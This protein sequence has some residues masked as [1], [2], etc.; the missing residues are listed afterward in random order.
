MALVDC[1]Y[2]ATASPLALRESLSAVGRGTRSYNF[3]P[4]SEPEV[5]RMLVA[6]GVSS[7]A[8]AQ[9]VI[10][11]A[12]RPPP[13]VQAFGLV[14]DSFAVAAGRP[15]VF[16]A[17]RATNQAQNTGSVDWRHDVVALVLREDHAHL[18]WARVIAALDFPECSFSSSSSFQFV[19]NVTLNCTSPFPTF[20][21]LRRPWANAR[22]HIDALRH[23]ISAPIDAISF[24]P[25]DSSKFI[26]A[27]GSPPGTIV[28]P[29]NQCFMNQDLYS[30]VLRLSQTGGPD[31]ALTA[32]A[33]LDAAQQQVPEI[34]L[35]A[36]ARSKVLE[37]CDSDPSMLDPV[38]L[39]SKV[40]GT[41]LGGVLGNLIVMPGTASV[42][43]LQRSVLSRLWE[44]SRPLTTTALFNLARALANR[45][46]GEH[47]Q[48]CENFINIGRIIDRCSILSNFPY[49]A[50]TA[51]APQLSMEVAV[52]FA[53]A[54]PEVEARIASELGTMFVAEVTNASGVTQKSFRLDAWLQWCLAEDSAGRILDRSERFVVACIGFIKRVI[55]SQSNVLLACRTR[56]GAPV[57]GSAAESNQNSQNPISQILIAA[58]ASAQDAAA[59]ESV[60]RSDV[61]VTVL[62]R[63]RSYHASNTTATIN[64]KAEFQKVYQSACRVFPLLNAL[65]DQDIEEHANMLFKKIYSS[66][67]NVVDFVELMRGFKSSSDSRE[68]DVFACMVQS[69]FKEFQYFHKYPDKELQI[70]GKLFGMLIQNNLIST[71]QALKQA[72]Q[73]VLEAI[74]KPPPPVGSKANGNLYRFGVY[75]LEQ[76]KSRLPG[77]PIFCSQISRI[78]HL[79]QQYPQFV[80]EIDALQI[81]QA[82]QLEL[83]GGSVGDLVD[84]EPL[85]EGSSANN[86]G[87]IVSSVDGLHHPHHGVGNRSGLENTG[88]HSHQ[89][90]SHESSSI[91][92]GRASSNE[93]STSSTLT[94]RINSLGADLTEA[95]AALAAGQP[96]PAILP[97]AAAAAAAAKEAE[98]RA[99]AAA[100]SGGGHGQGAEGSS[101]IAAGAESNAPPL[102]VADRV[103]FLV[104]NMTESN[105]DA[106]A[107]EAV[108]IL[109]PHHRTWLASYLV[110]KRV[111][112]QPNFQPLYKAFVERFASREVERF[113]DSELEKAILATTLEC[114]KR[115]LSNEKIKTSTTER[116]TLKNI[117]AW[118][119]LITL[120]RSK[121]LL[122][123]DLNM[124]EL[125]WEAY[126]TGKLFPVVGF[127]V[128]VLKCT[129]VSSVFRPPNPWTVAVLSA[130]RELYD[131]EDIKLNL[132]FEVEV[133]CEHLRLSF[134]MFLLLA[135]FIFVS[136][137]I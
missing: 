31:V 16:A 5:A 136:A 84:P 36:M 91:V 67:M 51:P 100:S 94:S 92:T 111:A 22:A 29:L 99:S 66:Q 21:L 114:A 7:A 133:L 134:K 12:P 103:T 74:K 83:K 75:A 15:V 125:L 101:G 96:I 123:K 78:P 135:I 19:V 97:S 85:L 127:I 119:G 130:L 106:E 53:M 72:L 63:L 42:Y 120:S 9:L 69:L 17:G 18:D 28:G 3:V 43:Q 118:L 55:A 64:T 104:N 71:P 4:L 93:T 122:Y 126:E 34:L 131:V 24:V 113:G 56:S 108:S 88:D 41:Q 46:V 59:R 107:A 112:N 52:Y 45:A 61:L 13:P 60:V 10:A 20:E 102:A 6:M 115:Y 121:P 62:K 25:Q 68:R 27:V 32:A 35:L 50:L 1:G 117:G 87:G 65:V 132:K 90:H 48:L 129:A 80:A 49:F 37:A 58:E 110:T 89:L 39:R 124:K 81:A 79:R 33:I 137:Q 105:V 47:E 116:S 2:S 76:F 40:F 95:L 86:S 30:V 38:P 77:W 82:Q 73:N 26:A 8:S 128:N 57:D 14:L 70:T 109:S 23:A 98:E 54:A 44:I 11:G